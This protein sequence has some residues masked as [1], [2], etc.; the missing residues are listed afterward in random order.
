MCLL[1]SMNNIRIEI[2][3]NLFFSLVSEIGSFLIARGLK[4]EQR[5]ALEEL[6]QY[7]GSIKKM[8]TTL[9]P[10]ALEEFYHYGCLS[11]AKINE[12]DELEGGVLE[13]SE[14]EGSKMKEVKGSTAE[15]SDSDGDETD[16]NDG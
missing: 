1:M 8:V 5:L 2:R 13:D 10:D 11:E 3:A 6:S 14:D 15:D 9:G 16:G 7:L 12:L 4:A